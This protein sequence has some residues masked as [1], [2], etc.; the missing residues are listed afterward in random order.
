MN[1]YRLFWWAFV[2]VALML[3]VT[4]CSGMAT[5]GVVT[6]KEHHPAYVDYQWTCYAY[7]KYGGCSFGM[8]VPYNVS[9]C[10]YV[11]FY[12]EGDEDWGSVCAS[13]D[14]YDRTNIG[15]KVNTK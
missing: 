10:W 14:V 11:E 1:F 8:D 13:K 6:S 5:S 3:I 12:N 4:G 15:D 9:E 7:D 2:I